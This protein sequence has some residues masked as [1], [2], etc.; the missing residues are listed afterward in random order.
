MEFQFSIPSSIAF[1]EGCAQ[2]VDHIVMG[3]ELTRVF[4]IYDPGVR[5]A[6]IAAGIVACLKNAG[7]EV[8]EWDGVVANPT[9]VVVEEGAR[10]AR[11]AKSEIVVAVGGGSVIDAGKAICVLLTNDSPIKQ[12]EGM[13]MVKIPA[14]PLV[15]IP[16]TAGTA[17]E[18]TA[19]SIVTDTEKLK[20]MVIGGQ[21]I[22]AS[23]ALIDPLL[24]VNLPQALTASTGMDALTHA[25]EAYLSRAASMPTDINALKAVELIAANLVEAVENGKNIEARANMLLGSMLAGFA[26]NSAVL[27][28]AHSIAHPLSVHSGLP[29]GVA[30]AAVLPYVMEFNAEAAPERVR[31]IGKAMGLDVS[32][33]SEEQ[34]VLETISAVKELSRK[35]GI[36]TLKEAGVSRDQFDRIA[37]DALQEV[38]TIFNPRDPNKEDVLKIL[39]KAY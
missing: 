28:L 1:G 15:A 4:C 12:Y 24:T 22:G 17:S 11:E 3:M 14:A 25:V 31:N 38:S 6:G 21:F 33:L 13:N 34:A 18:V 39:E 26:F 8:V 23:Y 9:D 2:S 30:N 16:T 32:G 36:P 19:F 5:N 37:K 20:K 10:L 35:I 7:L 27:G 29:H